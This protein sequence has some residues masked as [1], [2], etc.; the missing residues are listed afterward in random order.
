[1]RVWRTNAPVIRNAA[2][3]DIALAHAAHADVQLKALFHQIH[4]PVQQFQLYFQQGLLHSQC[5]QRRRQLAAAKATAAAAD[6]DQPFCHLLFLRHRLAHQPHIFQN[7]LRPL[8]HYLALRSQADMAGGAVKQT[9]LDGLFQQA[10]RLLTSALDTPITRAVS[11][12][13]R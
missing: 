3:N 7:A 5:R 4:C 6:A 2:G 1:M 10:I 9:L 13:L 11:A 8:M 12:K